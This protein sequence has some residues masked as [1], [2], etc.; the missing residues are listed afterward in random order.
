MLEEFHKMFTEAESYY[1][2]PTYDLTSSVQRG[3]L[4]SEKGN[5]NKSPIPQWYLGDSRFFWNYYMMNDLIQS[6]VKH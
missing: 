6:K 1:Y 2:S 3:V 5:D 4:S